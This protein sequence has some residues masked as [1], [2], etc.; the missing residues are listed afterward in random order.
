MSAESAVA[1]AT[2]KHTGPDSLDAVPHSRRDYSFWAMLFVFFGMQVPVSYFLTGGSVTAG[3]TLGRAFVITVV[4]SIVGFLILGAVGMIGWQ[5]GASTMACTRPAFGRYGSALP[6][7]IAFIE[8]TGWDS[9]HVQLAGKLMGSIG[10]QWGVGYTRLY[11]VIVGLAIVVVVLLGHRVLRLLERFLVPV[12]VVLVA[13]AL[14]AVLNGQD[15]TR[16]WQTAGKGHL[17]TMLAFDAMFI[18][19]LTWVPMV[20]DYTRYGKSRR[21]SFWSAFLSL[22]IA[23][24]MLF[25][26]QTAAVG[27]GNPN[28]LI[29][30]VHH[31]VVFGVIAFF[32]AMFA[33]IATAALIMYS[34]SM[35]LLNVMPQVPIRRINYGTGVV[36]IVA[37]V[38]MNLLGNVIN[39]LS[40][41]GIMLIPLFA[42]VLTDYY[43]VRKGHYEVAELF[44]PRGRYWGTGGFHITGLVAWVIGAIAYEVVHN[45]VPALGGGAVCFVVSCV[46]YWVISTVVRTLRGGT[47]DAARDVP[48]PSPLTSSLEIGE[49]S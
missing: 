10:A 8:L 1:A 47:E 3:L 15:L 46:V 13:M 41:Q 12:V 26:G 6:A 37:A 40:F 22:P 39:W 30:M 36:V 19:A 43:V 20:S 4:G 48:A 17:T 32:V 5:T 28:A 27:L 34:A 45:A 35:S 23:L 11:S 14:Y 16:L 24:F 49:S 38:T 21:S 33:T 31:G 29:A 18:S 44:R 2:A 7:L 42:I 25:V 9:V